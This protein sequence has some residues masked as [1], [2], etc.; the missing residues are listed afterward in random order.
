MPGSPSFLPLPSGA[1]FFLC[2]FP[3]LCSCYHLKGEAGHPRNPP[4]SPNGEAAALPGPGPRAALGGQ[5]SETPRG[6]CQLGLSGLVSVLPRSG[7][8]AQGQHRALA[9]APLPLVLWP[10]PQT[11][12]QPS[13]PPVGLSH[14]DSLE[15]SGWTRGGP[16]LTFLGTHWRPAVSGPEAPPADQRSRRL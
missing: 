4:R 15:A 1:P 9:P 14:R 2:L 11:A 16:G 3:A 12:A 5:N 13:V 7:S 10:R 6:G 8:W